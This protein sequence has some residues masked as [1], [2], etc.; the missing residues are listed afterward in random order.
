MSASL[1]SICPQSVYYPFIRPCRLQVEGQFSFALK[2]AA[3]QGLNGSFWFSHWSHSPH[4]DLLALAVLLFCYTC[5]SLPHTTCTFHLALLC[6]TR[7]RLVMSLRPPQ[8]V[9]PVCRVKIASV[10]EGDFAF[11]FI[12]QSTFV[13]NKCPTF[14]SQTRVRPG[15]SLIHERFLPEFDKLSKI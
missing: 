6:P 11:S 7:T 2:E 12:G 3:F 5:P 4:R 8:N 15:F 10:E 13:R 14:I 1:F 9:C